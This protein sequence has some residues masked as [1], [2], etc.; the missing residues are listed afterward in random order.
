MGVCEKYM[1]K[2]MVKA[3]ATKDQVVKC[4][5][6]KACCCSCWKMYCICLS[7]VPCASLVSGIVVGIGF[8]LFS[9]GLVKAF[10]HL[11]TWLKMDALA[12]AAKFAMY[13][14]IAMGV[15]SGFGLLIGCL[16]TGRTRFNVCGAWKTRFVGRCC[17]IMLIGWH[18]LMWVVWTFLIPIFIIPVIFM[19]IFYG[20]CAIKITKQLGKTCIFFEEYALDDVFGVKEVCGN[21]LIVFCTA[22][23]NATPYFIFCFVGTIFVVIG[24]VNMMLTL[25]ANYAHIKDHRTRP[26][27][28]EL[29]VG[30]KCCLV[31][32]PEEYFTTDDE[33]EVTE[34]L[35]T[36]ETKLKKYNE[37][38]EVNKKGHIEH[39]WNY[40]SHSS[41]DEKLIIGKKY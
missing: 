10:T 22:M 2:G 19:A 33:E 11:N 12:M 34:Q 13:F 18:Y 38:F 37:G 20:V 41:S 25:A 5:K 29:S 6:C 7:R 30:R 26:K 39:G 31:E 36:L 27:Q 15:F 40:M 3:G 16:A 14:G 24:V 23:S 21:E 4:R 9:F 35:I 8:F 17:V 32:D 28:S 1:V